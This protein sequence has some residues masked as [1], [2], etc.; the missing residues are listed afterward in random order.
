M[1]GNAFFKAFTDFF[2]TGDVHDEGLKLLSDNYD[3]LAAGK[4][5]TARIGREYTMSLYRLNWSHSMRIRIN[6]DGIP[7]DAM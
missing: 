2:V 6:A 3:S 5:E 4:A 1:I 7:A